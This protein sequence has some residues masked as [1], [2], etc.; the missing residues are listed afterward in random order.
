[1]ESAISIAQSR[2]IPEGANHPPHIPDDRWKILA[3]WRLSVAAQLMTPA[4]DTRAIAWKK[5]AL[6]GG[7]WQWSDLTEER[8]KPAIAAD[9]AFLNAHPTK[10]SVPMSNERKEERRKFKEAMRERIREIAASRDLSDEEIKPVLRLKHHEVGR[11]SEKHGINLAWLLEGR[12]PILEKDRLSLIRN[13]TGKQL[14]AVVSTLP[15]ADQ[16]VFK[17]MVDEVWQERDR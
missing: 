7:Q 13:M 8:I 3:K 2:G 14:A 5:T 12:G 6:A 16:Q 17:A 4:P 9:E 1:M 10:K 11:F 15:M